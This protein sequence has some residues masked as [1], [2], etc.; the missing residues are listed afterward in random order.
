MKDYGLWIG[1]LLSLPLSILANILTPKFQSWF[2]SRNRKKSLQKN[3]NLQ[4]E[5]EKVVK[6]KN[7]RQSFHEYLFWVV[8]RTTLIGSLLGVF[9]GIIFA[10]PNIFDILEIPY[11]E[12]DFI[13]NTLYALGQSMSV[14][15]ALM[16]V[17]TCSTALRNYYKVKNFDEYEKFVKENIS[18]TA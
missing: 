6:F 7:D 5:Y 3:R 1:L 9:A 11:S 17:N 10:I 16:I 8:I 18:S 4:A 15:G 14:I 2:D 13:R 12:I